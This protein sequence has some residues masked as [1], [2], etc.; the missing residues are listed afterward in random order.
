MLSVAFNRKLG[1]IKTKR[2]SERK[3][4]KASVICYLKTKKQ[5]ERN[6]G[7]NTDSRKK[8]LCIEIQSNT[9]A[10]EEKNGINEHQVPLWACRL[11]SATRGEA[12][13]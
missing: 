7:Q 3:H 1:F 4:Q 6:G 12:S 10:V 11:G 2:N 5:R 13:Q 8:S 9:H